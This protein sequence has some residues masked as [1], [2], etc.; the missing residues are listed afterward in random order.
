MVVTPS[1]TA[2]EAMALDAVN[3]GEPRLA[4]GLHLTLTAPFRPLTPDFAP[5]R[6][7]EFPSL[8]AMMRA[9]FLRQLADEKLNAEVAAQ[10]ASFTRAFGRPPAFVDGHQHV[11]LLPGV[12]DAVI[13]QVKKAA[14][15]AWL[16]QCGGGK[17]W[18][19]A[20]GMIVDLLSRGLRR[21][22]Q[23][24]GVS[25][26]PAFAGTYAF[27]D[28]ADYRV[29]FPRFLT[30]LPDGSVVMCHPGR[31]DA[32]LTRLD[33]LTH[34]REREYAYFLSDSFPRDLMRTGFALA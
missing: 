5:T 6:N 12:R 17:S 33:P 4:I 13:A 7:G 24:E 23:A 8:P 18:R 11:H 27:R 1:F 14:P 28:D 32:E 25:V 30:A 26:N 21:R 16:R 2:E 15:L 31:V 20:K 19:D 22:A 10:L 9:A 3:A 29:L 34:L